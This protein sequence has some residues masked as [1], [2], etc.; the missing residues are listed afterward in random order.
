MF[1]QRWTDHVGRVDEDF[2]ALRDS[3]H[4]DVPELVVIAVRHRGGEEELRPAEVHLVAVGHL[5]RLRIRLELADECART[6]PLTPVDMEL[7]VLQEGELAAEDGRRCGV[8]MVV[9]VVADREDVRLFRSLSND[10]P[11]FLLAGALRRMRGEVV[12]VRAKSDARVQQ[13]GDVRRLD[14]RCHR[15]RAEAVRREGRNL[16]RITARPHVYRVPTARISLAIA[17]AA[18]AGFPASQMARPTMPAAGPAVTS[19]DAFPPCAPAPGAAPACPPL[20]A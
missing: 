17:S 18:A 13:D 16:R 3:R 9:M 10:L 7:A 4:H 5:D 11:Q 19:P 2:A 20:P 15:S 14:E 6:L 1:L 12:A 8:V